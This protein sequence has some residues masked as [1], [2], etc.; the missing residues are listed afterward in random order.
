MDGAQSLVSAASSGVLADVKRL[1]AEHPHLL[2]AHSGNDTPLTTASRLGF[3]CVVAFLLDQGADMNLPTRRSLTAVAEASLHGQPR[4]V[5]LL[6]D[7]GAD[8]TLPNTRGWTPLMWASGCGYADVVA[9]LLGRRGRGGD[10]DWANESGHTALFRAC[11]NGHSH[12]ARMLLEAGADPVAQAVEGVT[13]AQEAAR[14]GRTGCAALLKVRD[15]SSWQLK[16]MTN[17]PP[18]PPPP[19]HTTGVGPLLLHP[20]PRPPPP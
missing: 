11:S 16:Q 9:L 13:P 3:T 17:P 12:V 2:N 15:R 14:Q 6:L 5:E 1:L 19:T 18:P 8:A 20:V 4:V 10:V 7:R